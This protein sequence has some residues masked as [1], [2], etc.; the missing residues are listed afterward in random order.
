MI[1]FDESTNPIMLDSIDSPFPV[2]YFWVLNL[3][4]MDFTLKE[5]KL[6]EELTTQKLAITINGF[7]V[8]APADWNI[9][10]YSR[11]TS[12][13]DTVAFSDL[14]RHDYTA[15]A[16]NHKTNKLVPNKIKVVDYDPLCKIQ[17]PSL[18]RDIMLCHPL[19]Y[20]MWVPISAT[21][22]YNKY[23]K[24]KVIGDLF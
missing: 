20:D 4:I 7:L 3:E 6:C 22:A 15:F 18:T 19:G 14:T 16:Y 12:E 10:V 9:L 23:L 1:I 17:T 8:E 13:L 2:E 11:E 21:D 24:D 5:L